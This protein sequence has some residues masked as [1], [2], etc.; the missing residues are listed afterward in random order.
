MCRLGELL[1]ILGAGQRRCASS[2]SC[3]QNREQLTKPAHNDP[4]KVVGSKF[5]SLLFLTRNA[6]RLETAEISAE[7]SFQ[8]C[9]KQ[10]KKGGQDASFRIDPVMQRAA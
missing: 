10:A 4:A 7:T 2:L 1:S 8:A 6:S 5:D 3:T 9:V